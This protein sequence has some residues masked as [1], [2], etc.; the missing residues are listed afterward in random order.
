MSRRVGGGGGRKYQQG[1][2]DLLNFSVGDERER[3]AGR[4][5]NANHH[6]HHHQHSGSG[7]KGNR[8]TRQEEFVLSNYRLGIRDTDPMNCSIG[9]R[10]VPWESIQQVVTWESL[11]EYRCPI[12][13]D[14]PK[15]AR[16]T[17]C[18]HIFCLP[19]FLQYKNCM[20][21][22]R[23]T[24][25]CPLCQVAIGRVSALRP[26]MMLPI[27]NYKVG[28]TIHLSL[29][30]REKDSFLGY[31]GMDVVQKQPPNS[32]QES[33]RFS[34]Y[35]SLSREQIEM[36]YKRDGDE[37]KRLLADECDDDEREVL[38]LA[39]ETVSSEA[40]TALTSDMVI[41]DE[42][43]S[44]SSTSSQSCQ[45][46]DNSTPFLYYQSSDG[47]YV[48]LS[49]FNMRMLHHSASFI[50]DGDPQSDVTFDFLPPFLEV[51]IEELELYTQNEWSLKRFKP[52]S[53]LPYGTHF[54]IAHVSLDETGLLDERTVSA[55]VD[56]TE[57]RRGQ[58]QAKVDREKAQEDRRLK[59]QNVRDKE[60]FLNTAIKLDGTEQHNGDN[61]PIN[62]NDRESYPS[63]PG[64][65]PLDGVLSSGGS[66]SAL[67]L[68][69]QSAA[70][71]PAINDLESVPRRIDA[72]DGKPYTEEEFFE[73]YGSYEEW[74]SSIEA[75]PLIKR[76]TIIEIQDE[77]RY[78]A[79]HV[80]S[81]VVR[82]P[83]TPWGVPARIPTQPTVST[84]VTSPTTP[85]V[86]D[87]AL[88]RTG[89][90]RGKRG[91]GTTISLNTGAVL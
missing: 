8:M 9:S 4:S 23:K 28:D 22:E 39:I 20:Q 14:P 89:K 67:F 66:D 52:L 19:C 84:A 75:A 46:D 13:L 18:G 81:P 31:H 86:I 82:S 64:S 47:Q 40:Q 38:Q 33:S 62:L 24:V 90:R 65:H 49:G 71:S 51:K 41:A 44:S 42:M 1:Y 5:R 25:S 26:V 77:E 15:C 2:K 85:S 3:G 32:E 27:H 35:F 17:K 78:A 29:V 56:Q 16:I 91:K 10:V 73:C 53:Q 61:Q 68:F 34:R 21:Q 11:E 88:Q 43:F 30:R 36:M 69:Q 72:S 55:F 80:P 12:C 87:N 50:I 83:I 45:D 60:R 6:H 63:L 54:A 79:A 37:L 48:Y 76:K 7:G 59:Q 74:E 58:R 70:E 57:I